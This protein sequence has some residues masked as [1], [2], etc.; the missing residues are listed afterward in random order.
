MRT[1]IVAHWLTVCI[2]NNK[3]LKNIHNLKIIT[4]K[5]QSTKILIPTMKHYRKKIF[6]VLQKWQWLQ[7]LMKVPKSLFHFKNDSYKNVLQTV[8]LVKMLKMDCLKT[9]CFISLTSISVDVW[10]TLKWA[11]KF[12]LE[13]R[14]LVI[15][16]LDL[17]FCRAQCVLCSFF[18]LK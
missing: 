4:L 14:T 9:S 5:T 13:I 16:W 12:W 7:T 1:K 15:T 17:Y 6:H 11:E 8:S 2:P 3:N 10:L 18:K